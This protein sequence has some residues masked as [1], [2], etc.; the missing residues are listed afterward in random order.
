MTDTAPATGARRRAA[1]AF[2]FVTILID[3]LSFGL[4]IPVLPHLI[5]QFAGGDTAHA[6]YWVA[7]FGFLFAEIGRA[8]CR[9]RV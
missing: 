1:L 8:S 2:I 9:E 3:V 5:E 6:A 7:A 4:I